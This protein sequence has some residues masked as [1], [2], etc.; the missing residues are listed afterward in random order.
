[1]NITLL[2]IMLILLA[3]VYLSK[4]RYGLLGL[5]LI[6]GSIISAS[7][8]TYVTVMLQLQ[9]VRLLSPPLN[10]VVAIV[11]LLLPVV[12]LLF[13][14]PTYRKKWQKISGSLLFAILA[15]LLIAAAIMRETPSL[16]ADSQVGAIATQA[17]PLIIVVG[18]T[19]AI[20]DTVMAHRPK[21]GKKS[22][23]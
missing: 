5:A 13:V 15:T 2:I 12:F 18:V 4:R 20:V 21:K 8:S 23:D 6:A 10:V 19:V 7:W 16:M 22:A 1:M 17:Y 11:L 14:G 3:V 9:G